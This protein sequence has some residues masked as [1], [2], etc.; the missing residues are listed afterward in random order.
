MGDMLAFAEQMGMAKKLES[1]SLGQGQGPKAVRLIELA[2]QQG[3]WV[4]LC[5]RS[6]QPM[7]SGHRRR[8][9]TPCFRRT[10]GVKTVTI[11]YASLQ[12]VWCPNSV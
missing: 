2:R 11:Q 3:G 7:F 5:S 12:A 9:E 4:L 10:G 8:R 6:S 1:I